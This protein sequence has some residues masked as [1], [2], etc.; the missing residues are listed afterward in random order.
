MR[1][2]VS[3]SPT[4]AA[5]ASPRIPD[6]PVGEDRLVLAGG[7]DPV[8]VLAGHVGGDEHP[9]EPR[10]GGVERREVTDREACVGMRRPDGP[11]MEHVDGR[12]IRA[13]GRRADDLVDPVDARDPRPDSGARRRRPG[14]PR[15]RRRRS[16]ASTILR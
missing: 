9:H 3:A 2:I 10:I 12:A 14:R 13:E 16:T 15:S 8:E 6:V 1:A 5:T 7:I 11:Q 4:R